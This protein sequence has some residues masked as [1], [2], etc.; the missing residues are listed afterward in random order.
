MKKIL[1]IL[2]CLGLIGCA[3]FCFAQDTVIKTSLNEPY[4]TTITGIVL[5]YVNNKPLTDST[6]N[7]CP[8]TV[9]DGTYIVVRYGSKSAVFYRVMDRI[10]E[11][12]IFEGKAITVM[13]K[14]IQ[15]AGYPYRK[16]I[17]IES[18]LKK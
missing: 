12:R 11:V 8:Y 13:G 15:P 4:K 14:V 6:G 10:D 16:N 5:R 7:Y 3:T 9:D 1:I 18:E 2:L 17:W